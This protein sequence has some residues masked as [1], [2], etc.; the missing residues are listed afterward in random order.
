L[1]AGISTE[2]GIMEIAVERLLGLHMSAIHY[3]AFK[4]TEG[5]MRFVV[6]ESG[7]EVIQS[8][9][10]SLVDRLGERLNLVLQDIGLKIINLDI[11]KI[12]VDLSGISPSVL[13]IPTDTPI[14]SHSSDATPAEEE[15]TEISEDEPSSSHQLS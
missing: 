3:L 12:E 1:I 13:D 9:P 10:D 11:Q 2:T 7:A 14:P 8:D 6:K 15:S 5:C 4:I